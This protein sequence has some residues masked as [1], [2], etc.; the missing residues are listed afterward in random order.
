M[1]PVY[2]EPDYTQESWKVSLSKS[3]HLVRLY[4]IKK[5]T[6]HN[7][8]G[9]ALKNAGQE[10]TDLFNE[11]WDTKEKYHNLITYHIF[12]FWKWKRLAKKEAICL[13]C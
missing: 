11:W 8:H 13:D 2:V 6:M 9:D 3:D 7:L 5:R 4:Y 1:T 10:L 12:G